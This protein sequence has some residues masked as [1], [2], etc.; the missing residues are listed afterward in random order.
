[1]AVILAPHLHVD[2]VRAGPDV[3]AVAHGSLQLVE[4]VLKHPLWVCQLLGDQLGDR[5]L[6]TGGTQHSGACGEG[7]KRAAHPAMGEESVRLN[8]QMKDPN[9]NLKARNGRLR[10]SREGCA[11]SQI[12]MKGDRE[13]L[14][15]FQVRVWGNNGP[16]CEVDSLAGQVASEAPRLALQPLDQRPP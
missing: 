8:Q 4:V 12:C 6:R 10:I 2:V 11:N 15:H 3:W 7:G 9:G 14:E 13:D 5:H 1:M 16:P